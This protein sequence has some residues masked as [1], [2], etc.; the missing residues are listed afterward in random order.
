[1][2]TEEYAEAVLDVVAQI[3]EGQVLAY[4]DVAEILGHGGPRN[5]GAVMSRYGS[6]VPWWRVIRADGR[7]P[8]GLE[9]EAIA[10]WRAEGTPMVRGSVVGGRVDMRRARWAGPA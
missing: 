6:D 7:A 10:R 3:P 2:S 8:D 9:A 4:G 1:M 5:V